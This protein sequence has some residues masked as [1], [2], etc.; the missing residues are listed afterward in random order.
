M[1]KIK[2]LFSKNNFNKLPDYTFNLP[3]YSGDYDEEYEE[4]PGV[5]LVCEYPNKDL[6]WLN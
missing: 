2:K 6:K 5:K 4:Y 1:N 3:V